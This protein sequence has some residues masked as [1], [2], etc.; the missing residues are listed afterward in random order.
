MDPVARGRSAV[1]SL[2]LLMAALPLSACAASGPTS[3]APTTEPEATATASACELKCTVVKRQLQESGDVNVY[4]LVGTPTGG[5]SDI[6]GLQIDL[7]CENGQAVGRTGDRSQNLEGM[8]LVVSVNE[9]R[10]YTDTNQVYTIEGG[11]GYEPTG[12]KV[13]G[14]AFTVSGGKLSGPQTCKGP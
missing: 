3:A 10:T 13:E 8:T 2:S 11:L 4:S 1:L 7:T 6:E 5:V 12:S 9:E 14:Y